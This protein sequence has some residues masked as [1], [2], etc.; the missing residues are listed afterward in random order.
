MKLQILA[1]FLIGVTLHS[2]TAQNVKA[3]QL[4]ERAI[5]YHDPSG[6]WESFNGHIRVEMS[7]SKGSSRISDIH[8]NLPEEFF[9][10]SATQDAI[11]RTYIIDRDSCSMQY[12]SQTI[13]KDT[14]QT[15]N[16]NCDRGLLYKNYYTYLYGLPM[17][18]KDP[19]TI[20]DPKIEQRTFKDKTYLVLKVSYEKTVGQDLWFF[21]FDPQTYAMEVYQFFKTDED[22]KVKPDSGE[23]ILLSEETTVNGI[24]MPKVREWYYNKDDAYLG[25]DTLVK[26]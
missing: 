18:L 1:S 19:G 2:L 13:T 7:T 8:I 24:K 20:I 26:T 21:Y 6:S 25:T 10:V 15:K 16:M 9:S 14:A 22:G 12:N 5:S 11:T 3:S 17:K 4:L 23:Y